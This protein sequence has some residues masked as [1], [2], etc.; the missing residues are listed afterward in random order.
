M[1][2]IGDAVDVVVRFDDAFAFLPLGLRVVARAARFLVMGM[3][4]GQVGFGINQLD[5]IYQ[6]KMNLYRVYVCVYIYEELYIY[7]HIDSDTDIDLD[8]CMYING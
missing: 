1:A 2:V 4:V 7:T 8:I 3:V 5:L 6:I